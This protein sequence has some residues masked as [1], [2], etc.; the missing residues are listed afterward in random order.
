M[1]DF[2]TLAS[3]APK[4]DPASC[5]RHPC[6]RCM[7][8][9]TPN[10]PAPK[11]H[12]VAPHKPPRLPSPFS[13]LVVP[14]TAAAPTVSGKLA[15]LMLDLASAITDHGDERWQRL[16]DW[17]A[18]SLGISLIR[19]EVG[20][21]DDKPTSDGPRRG[22]RLPE[23]RE[24]ELAE[25]RRAGRYAQEV[26]DLAAKTLR[27]L[28]LTPPVVSKASVSRLRFLLA[29]AE[30]RR[31]RQL[32][33]REITAA[34]VAADGWCRSCYRVGVFEP[35]S[36]RPTGEPYYRDLCRW[37]GQNRN[38]LE[39]PSIDMVRTHHRLPMRRPS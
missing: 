28:T 11:G 29:V 10:P 32:K 34:Q 15:Q 4:H 25:D 39:Q 21:D 24:R 6:R 36:L 17:E 9:H 30:Q 19:P 31:P 2:A 14:L 35:I 23:D 38:G 12:R 16:C 1:R 37:C 20:D 8:D 27:S 13:S 26:R 5:T 18:R 22:S 33:S 7:G 3:V